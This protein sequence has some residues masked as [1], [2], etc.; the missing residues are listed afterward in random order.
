[1]N[2]IK[3]RKDLHKIP[4]LGRCEFKT[5]E[6]LL[7]ILKNLNAEIF[8]PTPTAVVAY[9]NANK[10]KTI[11]FRADMDA[12]QIN[13]ANNV[14]Y[15]SIHPGFMHACG[16]DGHMAM[17]LDYA[18]WASDNLDKLTSNV[19]CLFQPS[20][21]DKAGALDI[22]QS[23]ILDELEVEEIYG[24]HIWPTLKENE[25]YTKYDALLASS[26]ELNIEFYGKSVHAANFNQGID[27]LKIA[28]EFMLDFYNFCE[29]IKTKHLI[30]FGKFESGKTRNI[31]SDYTRI[32]ATMRNFDDDTFILMKEELF[33]LKNKYQNKF[34]IKI[35]I[36]LND[37]YKSVINSNELVNK[38]K[39]SLK[40]NLLADS[41]MQ[42]EDFGCY[43]RKYKSMFMLLGASNKVMLHTNNFDFNM[44]IL[45][46]GV[47][48]YKII[49][50]I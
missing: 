46:T 48:A 27:A 13:E 18:T 16:H 17:L 9:F 25:L 2:A 41:F 49:S 14:E 10:N 35:N 28:A 32:E 34:G 21:E 30:S 12:L 4:E 47:N 23:N 6:Y 19:V 40:L 50:T 3:Y 42:A 44:E 22:I 11:C 5:K 39:N 24:I 8:L 26:S 1:M 45:E 15:K 36:E 37:L 29:K 7:N 43:T 38:Y 20:E 33:N 31:I